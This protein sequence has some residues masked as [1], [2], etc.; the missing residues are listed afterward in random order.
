MNHW[1]F[2]SQ[3]SYK[4][5]SHFAGFLGGESEGNKEHLPCKLPLLPRPLGITMDRNV[6]TWSV[7]T[8]FIY[9]FKII[10]FRVPGWFPF[11]AEFPSIH[12]YTGV[13]GHSSCQDRWGNA[14]FWGW[15]VKHLLSVVLFSLPAL[16]S[17]HPPTF[18]PNSFHIQFSKLL[19]QK[20]SPSSQSVLTA[21]HWPLL[22]CKNPPKNQIFK[23]TQN[24]QQH[25]A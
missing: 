21:L 2:P 25:Q 11:S 20:D 8:L 17:A 10:C 7:H 22:N 19:F 3:C 13:K 4:A 1:A 16:F 14:I 6:L 18:Y 23:K 24:I 5:H 9:S 15:A 12:R